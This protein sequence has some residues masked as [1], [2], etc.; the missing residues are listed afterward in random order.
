MEQCW[1]VELCVPI[2]YL[3]IVFSVLLLSYVNHNN[4]ISS[5]CF[6]CFFEISKSKIIRNYFTVPGTVHNS[7]TILYNTFTFRFETFTNRVIKMEKE[8]GIIIML[9]KI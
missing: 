5:S 7:F 4:L 1:L 8:Q 3:I 9:F 2:V 6:F